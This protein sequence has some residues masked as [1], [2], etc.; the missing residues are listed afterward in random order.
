MTDGF[1]FARL[2]AM[3]RKEWLQM[4]R[5]KGTLRLIVVLPL[6]QIFLFG[7]AINTNA[8]HLPTALVSADHSVYERDLVTALENTAYFDLRPYPSAAAA[9]RALAR[10]DVLFVLEIPPHFA[11]EIDRDERPGVLMDVDATDPTAVGDATAAALA[12]NATALSRDLPPNLQAVIEPPPFGIVL[13]D[14]YNPD[15][16]TALNI[17]PGLLGMILVVSTLVLTAVAVTREREVGT[18]ENLLSMPIR[19]AEVMLGKIIPYVGLGYVQVALILIV[20]TLVFGVP[21]RGSLG[22]LLLA[23]GLF[24]ACNLA[25]GF[26]ISTVSRTQRQAQQLAQFVFMPSMLLSGFMF[27]FAGMPGWA[28]LIGEALPITHI[29]RITRGIMLKGNGFAVILP[30]LWPMAL[31]AVLVAVAAAGL[32]RST[33]D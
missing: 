33:L 14:R 11:R 18:L 30:D 15:Q 25:L 16:I 2:A 23:L 24:I 12:V 13:H 5:D 17:V 8:R 32:Y 28:R 10:G 9:D 6:I 31:F 7:L 27:P 20:A 21:L 4:L 1:S 29:L 3:L 19:P 26:V 22:L